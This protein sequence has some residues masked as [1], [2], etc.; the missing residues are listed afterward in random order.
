[1]IFSSKGAMFFP[2]FRTQKDTNG[3]GSITNI[4]LCLH[5]SKGPFSVV[6]ILIKFTFAH[7]VRQRGL[8]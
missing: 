7:K 5:I 2:L 6:G 8:I 3:T 4:F 1:M